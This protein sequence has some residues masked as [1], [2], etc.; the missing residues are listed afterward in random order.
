[1]V[2][3]HDPSLKRCFGVEKKV[4]ECDWEY[5]STLTTVGNQPADR[6]PR[7]VDLLEFLD[8][9]RFEHVWVLLDIKVCHF[10]P[11]PDPPSR[12]PNSARTER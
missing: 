4:A 10:H 1:M 5:L 8:Q 3:D 7:L 12:G 2:L 11:L 6:M 9:E